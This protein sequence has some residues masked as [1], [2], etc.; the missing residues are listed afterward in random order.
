VLLAAVAVS[1]AGAFAAASVEVLDAAA[2]AA[3]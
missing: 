2:C 3:G 1:F